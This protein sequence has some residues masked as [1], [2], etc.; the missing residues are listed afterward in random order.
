MKIP[1]FYCS[2]INQGK[3]ELDTTSSHHATD[4]YRLRMGSEIE[5]FDGKGTLARAIIRQCKRNKVTVDTTSIS[6]QPAPTGPDIVIASS[7]AKGDRFSWLISK[8]TELGVQRIMPVIFKRTVKQANNRNILQ[9]YKKLTI[10]AAQQSRRIFLPQIDPPRSLDEVVAVVGRDYHQPMLLSGTLSE[11][12]KR[13]NNIKLNLANNDAVVAFIGPEGGM[14]EEENNFLRA[15]NARMVRLTRS[16]LR[17]E[18]AAITFAALL[19]VQK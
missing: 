3:A 18:T 12:A 7:L 17:I 14:T 9:R 10:A 11:Q 15:N 13:I 8:C 2:P 6:T 5:L 19:C 16:I 4:V 1:R